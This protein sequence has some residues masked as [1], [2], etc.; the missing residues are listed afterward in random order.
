MG[1]GTVTIDQLISKVMEELLEAGMAK[2]TLWG[3]A[4]YGCY[5]LISKYYQ[6]H[7][8][9]VYSD[10]IMNEYEALIA[11]QF[12]AGELCR[13]YYRSR[14]KAVERLR[15]FYKNGR[16][17][18]EYKPKASKFA[19]NAYHESLLSD[20]LKSQTYSPNT[21]GDVA[22]AVRKYLNFIESEGY[23]QLGE[24]NHTVLQNFFMYCAQELS[25]SSVHNLR[26]YLH[27]FYS[28]AYAGKIVACSYDSFFRF[29]V[30]R[31]HKILPCLPHDEINLILKQI[32]L[33]TGKGKRD[34]AMILLGLHTG[35]RAIDIVNLK[36]KDIDWKR[37]EIR[38]VQQKTGKAL[39]LP[40]ME[41]VAKALMDYILSGRPKSDSVYIFLRTKV[42]F[43]KLTDGVA[44]G[45]LFDEY[46]RKAGIPREP[47]DGKGFHALRR[48][49]G[50]DM[51]VAGTPVTTV[52]QVLGQADMN[53]AKQYISLD[54]EHL[55][56]CA[57][58]FHGIE[59]GGGVYE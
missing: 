58:G 19:I 13:G 4:Y 28:Y 45:E 47:W 8:Q 31:G 29:P 37:G 1:K 17:S 56:I 20:F 52:A 15:E 41:A 12:E 25:C 49:I 54:S 36:L 27:R 43:E 40:L 34:L 39:S 55:K 48:T 46:Q 53:S 10:D 5:R 30:A 26:L 14:Q 50:K 38:I 22:W 33:Y 51:V 7:K 35:L 24:T 23:H 57:L 18:W 11:T 42:P 16:L 32:N 21:Q 2:Q 3:S 9:E 44:V 6:Q 59:I